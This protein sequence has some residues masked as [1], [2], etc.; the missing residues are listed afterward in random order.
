MKLARILLVMAAVAFA[1]SPAR[2]VP[3]LFQLADILKADTIV[4]AKVHGSSASGVDLDVERSLRGTASGAF[5]ATMPEPGAASP[6]AVGT[7]LV[8]FVS[9][10]VWTA[11]ALAG[12]GTLESDVL[13]VEALPVCCDA[14]GVSPAIATLAQ[15]ESNV[16]G[17]AL[18]WTFR[19][20]L[21]LATTSGPARSTIDI[22][23]LAPS[24]VVRGL[25]TMAGYAA[26]TV[27]VGYGMKGAIML[28][29]N[30][31]TRRAGPLRIVGDATGKNPDGSIAVTYRVIDP[32]GVSERDFRRF[33][34]DASLSRP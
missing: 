32:A 22:E 23:V 30:V 12:T 27:Q 29:W 13:H 4:I 2:A 5:H 21:E 6:Y 7:R 11:V 9:H 8:A 33:V 20:N 3:M 25:P 28:T 10:G 16:R 26:P 34:A 19:G 31:T 24:S 18:A 15:I 1:T 14:A 17:T